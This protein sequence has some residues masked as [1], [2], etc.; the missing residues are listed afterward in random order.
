[1]LVTLGVSVPA[2][3]ASL[4]VPTGGSP[5]PFTG[6][7]TPGTENTLAAFEAAIG[8]VDNGTTAGERGSGFR[9]VSWDG[10]ALDGSDPGSTVINPGHVVALSR[11]RLEPWGIELGPQVAVADD[12]FH[13]VNSAAQFTPYS[14]P[15]VW[16]PFNS[17]TTELQIVA[18]GSPADMAQ[19][20]QTRGLG[21]VFL[22]VTAANQTTIQY[23]NGDI[24]LGTVSAPI[25]STSFAGLLFPNPVVT[26]VVVTLGTGEIFSFNGS[27]SPGPPTVDLVAGDD[28]ALAEPAPAESTVAATAGVPVTAALDA[29]TESTP[30][31]T[32]TATIDWGDG[33]RTGGTITP[34]PGGTF[35]VNGDHAYAQAGSYIASVTVDDAEGPGQT[36]Q[37]DI[38][39]AP[40]QTTTSVS[41]SPADVAVS[42][43]TACTATVQDVDAGNS[44]P[45]A[46]LVTFASPTAGTA[47]PTTGSC[48]LGAGNA[49]TSFCQVQFMA[50][51]R[52]P[53]QARITA[54]YAGDDAHASSAGDT[55]IAVHA[56]SCTLQPL[57]RR[58]RAGGF[59]LI[60]TCD[61]RA[62]VQVAA[63][64]HAA[65]RGRQRAFQLR[66]GSV[67][68]RVTAGRPTVLVVKAA[69]GVLPSLRAAHQRHQRVTLKLTLSVAASQAIHKS[70]TTRVSLVRFG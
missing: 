26:R 18:P 51:Q 46:G 31:A 70:T 48:V 62:T 37:T 4:S 45:P 11:T 60:V 56:R 14:P 68:S 16:A 49:R 30:R 65:R 44:S 50:G 59:A 33:A 66:F 10:I 40:G 47:F 17:N 2:V 43:T 3:R 20:A 19:P 61:A 23:Y 22:N 63:E 9:H 7:G 54:S 57:S 64:A 25:G 32:V 35:V 42:A 52:P 27:A 36:K 12:G 5:T 21:V 15:N 69:P 53:V 29:F 38:Q 6:A 28:M 24:S 1:M 8:G 34:G 13:S 67:S 58:L 55:T 39:V 41:C